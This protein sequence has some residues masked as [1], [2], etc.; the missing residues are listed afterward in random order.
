M[1]A[2]PHDSPLHVTVLDTYNSQFLKANAGFYVL[3]MTLLKVSLCAFFLKI[4]TIKTSW[5]RYVIHAINAFAIAYGIV[6]FGMTVGT[7][8]AASFFGSS[9]CSYHT[10]YTKINE[11]WSIINAITDFILVGL[12]VQAI[13]TASLPTPTKITA[14]LVLVLGSMGG[15]ASVIRI[16]LLST[17]LSGVSTGLSAAYWSL[18]EASIGI[19][20]ASLATLRPLLR[21]CMER[22]QSKGSTNN[23]SAFNTAANGSR[24]PTALRSKHQMNTVHDWREDRI[25]MND[26]EKGITPNTIVASTTIM[27]EEHQ[28]SDTE[29]ETRNLVAK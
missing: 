25:Q 7:C 21:S 12:T 26:I 16:I 19:A 20:A 24:V 17:P 22:V 15:V 11:S 13:W 5:Q 23:R 9:S 3:T 18:I 29:L 6:T 28:L 4:F 10:A 27:I 2:R 14:S 8:G 1:Y